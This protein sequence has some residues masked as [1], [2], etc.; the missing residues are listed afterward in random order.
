[1]LQTGHSSL[2]VMP[3]VS[4]SQPSVAHN[5]INEIPFSRRLPACIMYSNLK[6]A[7]AGDL[8]WDLLTGGTTPTSM[9]QIPAGKMLRCAQM[10][11][12]SLTTETIPREKF[13]HSSVQHL[14]QFVNILDRKRG[15]WAGLRRGA[16]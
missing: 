5:Q 16:T 12:K 3:I 1:M 14:I 2:P 10:L 4:I 8:Q 6:S 7:I 13:N 15:V 9:R 11:A